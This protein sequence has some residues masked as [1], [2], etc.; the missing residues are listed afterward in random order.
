MSG[1]KTWTIAPNETFPL[2][3]QRY[4]VQMGNAIHGDLLSIQR[5]PLPASMPSG[6]RRIDL[7]SG[8]LLFL[9]SGW[10][11]AVESPEPSM[12]LMFIGLNV[13]WAD[14]V[15]RALRISLHADPR[16]REF[17]RGGRSPN[18]RERDIGA[19]ELDEL[20]DDLRARLALQSARVLLTPTYVR[21]SGSSAAIDGAVCT[22]M[23]SADTTRL[24]VGAE[25]LYA[26]KAVLAAADKG[27]FDD[28]LFLD[29][30]Y[31]PD[32]IEALLEAL[33]Q[34]GFLELDP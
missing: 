13:N 10:W 29:A 5:G 31:D 24:E 22:L 21:A 12:A 30:G 23:T 8:S 33:V 6:A 34:A 16:W 17:A 3:T 14:V 11:H 20:L 9:P 7:E 4:S 18:R 27:R 25:E 2:P 1:R 15:T 19:R 26:L 28:V 32:I